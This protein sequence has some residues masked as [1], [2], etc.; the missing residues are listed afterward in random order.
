[1]VRELL[2]ESNA[3][4][5]NEYQFGEI[6]DPRTTRDATQWTTTSE[7]FFTYTHAICYVNRGGGVA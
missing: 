3:P 7:S 4:I 2:K 6:L 5:F 1:M